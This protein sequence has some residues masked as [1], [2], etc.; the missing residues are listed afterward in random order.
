MCLGDLAGVPMMASRHCI[1][2]E[3]MEGLVRSRG[4]DLNIVFRSDD[5]GT[6][7]GLVGTGMAVALV[8]LLAVET[9][10]ERVT[11]LRL[12]EE[13]PDRRIALAWHRDRARSSAARAF[14]ES[15]AAGL[16]R[17][18]RDGAGVG[19][20]PPGRRTRRSDRACAA[21]E[22]AGRQARVATTSR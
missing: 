18:P 10:D 9:T 21:T 6:V 14:I 13:L 17:H 7:Q 16:R 8:P 5:N 2:G 12:V 1:S 19:L 22:S 11:L 15:N 4:V 20:D 3:Y